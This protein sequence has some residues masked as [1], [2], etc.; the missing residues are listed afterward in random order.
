MPSLVEKATKLRSEVAELW[1]AVAKNDPNAAVISCFQ[2]E[3]LAVKEVVAV[4][5]PAVEKSHD[6]RMDAENKARSAEIRLSLV[7]H[8]EKSFDEAMT[9]AEEELFAARANREDLR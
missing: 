5:L 3:L 9:T 7:K 1:E 8:R 6:L 4:L 2:K